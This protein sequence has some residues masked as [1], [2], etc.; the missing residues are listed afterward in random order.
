MYTDAWYELDVYNNSN[1]TIACWFANVE[2][3]YPDTL[4]PEEKPSIHLELLNPNEENIVYSL[5]VSFDE[6]FDNEYDKISIYV[7][8]KD[9]LD[10]Y[11]WE[12][13]R[14]N[15][16]LLIRYDLSYNDIKK[17]NY[18]IPFPPTEVMKNMQMYPSY[19]N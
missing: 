12:E 16:R 7:F 2:S 10:K 15:Y 17:L 6:W 8:S 18:S 5:G 3:T 11:N 9:T 14:E 1:D 4:L 13:I 19:G